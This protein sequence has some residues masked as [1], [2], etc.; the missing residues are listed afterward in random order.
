MWNFL[1]AARKLLVGSIWDL[2]PLPGIKPR[3]TAWGAPSP[4]PWTTR[5]VPSLHIFISFYPYS[6][7]LL[8]SLYSLGPP[9]QKTTC[10]QVYV[11]GSAFGGGGQELKQSE[12]KAL[13]PAWGWGRTESSN[14]GA[15]EGQRWT[16]P[17]RTPRAAGICGVLN[18][19][20][21]QMPL[22]VTLCF[23]FPS[24]APKLSRQFG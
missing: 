19:I 11:S 16:C 12:G 6:A 13:G 15:S 10:T 5:E 7:S 20:L 14:S 18:A 17:Y 24:V 2:V 1:L 23:V 22:L 8:L 9:P 3:P 21:I 4:N